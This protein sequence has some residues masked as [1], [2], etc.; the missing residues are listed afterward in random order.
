M[1]A[2]RLCDVLGGSSRVFAA[3]LSGNLANIGYYADTGN[4][5]AAATQTVGLI[6]GTL[7][8]AACELGIAAATG[9]VGVIATAGRY[10]VGT[11][12]S[13]VTTGKVF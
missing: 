4:S 3:S 6:T 12:V 11:A 10:A 7:A 2:V 13:N 9:G 5:K 8:G 1:G